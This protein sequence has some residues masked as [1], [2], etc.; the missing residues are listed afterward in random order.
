MF[1][2]V[3]ALS[4]FRIINHNNLALPHFFL[5][6][7]VHTREKFTTH[8]HAEKM[9][10]LHLASHTN[11]KNVFQPTKNKD[12]RLFNLKADGENSKKISKKYSV[13]K[14]SNWKTSVLQ[15][16]SSLPQSLANKNLPQ[17]SQHTNM[18]TSSPLEWETLL[19]A[20]KTWFLRTRIHEGVWDSV[21]YVINWGLPLFS[22][23][24]QSLEE[25]W[26]SRR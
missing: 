9:W 10:H 24:M 23:T 8:G 18:F 22:F 21:A 7:C 3:L 2:R 19:S 5:N 6:T 15:A 12:S 17:G 14:A 4:V 20:H 25:S 13:P 16:D 26:K 11:P 1:E